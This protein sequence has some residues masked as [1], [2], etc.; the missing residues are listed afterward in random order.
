MDRNIVLIGMMGCGKTT[1]GT[2][3]ARMLEFA[4]MVTYAS[5]SRRFPFKPALVFRPGEKR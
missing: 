3:L 1:V 4:V 5:R 2:L